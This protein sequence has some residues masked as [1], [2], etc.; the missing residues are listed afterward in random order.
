MLREL[1]APALSREGLFLSME[2]LYANESLAH[3][4]GTGTRLMEMQDPKR[5]LPAPEPKPE[6]PT[7]GGDPIAEGSS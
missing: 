3:S 6:A 2:R 7:Q 4:W 5:G 1:G